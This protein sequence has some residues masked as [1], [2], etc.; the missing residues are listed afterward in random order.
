MRLLSW[1]SRMHF[2]TGIAWNS[3]IFVFYDSK[4]LHVQKEKREGER[5]RE[6]EREKDV[7]V[8]FLHY[9]SKFFRFIKRV[10]YLCH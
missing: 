4:I 10:I 6:I 7:Y 5:E 1:Q 9:F 8:L 3:Q 2:Y